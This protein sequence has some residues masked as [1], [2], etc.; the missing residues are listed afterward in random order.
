EVGSRAIKVDTDTVASVGG[1]VSKID[2]RQP[3]DDMHKVNFA[4]ALGKKPIVLVFA[5][6]ALC[7]SRVCGPVVDMVYQVESEHRG[8]A[9]FIHEE[10]YK[11]NDPSQGFRPQVN[12]WHLP[13][14]PWIFGID[15]KGKIVA[16]LEGAATVPAVEGVVKAAVKD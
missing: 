1:D 2:T 8:E 13:T 12:A 14:E 11:N 15:R 16:R 5:T 4:D 7:Q 6:P 3:P 9:V 10:I